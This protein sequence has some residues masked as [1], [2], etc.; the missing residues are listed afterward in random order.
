MEKDNVKPV[1]VG[2]E[3]SNEHATLIPE[4]ITLEG[5]VRLRMTLSNGQDLIL[6]LE[7][8]TLLGQNA[9]RMQSELNRSLEEARFLKHYPA[10]RYEENKFSESKGGN[11]SRRMATYI[12]KVLYL[13][14]TDIYSDGTPFLAWSPN[15]SGVHGW[16][17]SL[18]GIDDSPI[19]WASWDDPQGVDELVTMLSDQE[20]CVAIAGIVAPTQTSEMSARIAAKALRSGRKLPGINIAKVRKVFEDA[21]ISNS[22]ATEYANPQVKVL[23]ISSGDKR[24]P[25]AVAVSAPSKFKNQPELSEEQLQG[26]TWQQRRQAEEELMKPLVEEWGKKLDKAFSDAGWRAIDLPKPRYYYGYSQGGATNWYT[27]INPELWSNVSAAATQAASDF[28]FSRATR[29]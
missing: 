19:G 7:T 25:V 13:K 23:A 8:L 5:E 3:V 20:S 17:L 15:E 2:N 28:Y 4:V 26:L 9:N 18:I 11:R 14:G 29:I 16:K 1:F 24:V 27:L 12:S 6:P 10:A 22:G 21:G